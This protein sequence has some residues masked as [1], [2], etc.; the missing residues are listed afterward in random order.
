MAAQFAR[1][2]DLSGPRM[3]LL[4]RRYRDSFP[5][6]EVHPA[7]DPRFEELRPRPPGALTVK[8]EQV[9]TPRVW[10]VGSNEA[11]L[12]QLQ[13]DR[14]V[15]NWRRIGGQDYPRYEHVRAEFLKNFEIFQSFLADEGLGI[16]VLNQWE[17]TYVNH[18]P[19]RSGWNRHGELDSVA[20]VLAGSG[21]GDFL[22]EPEDIALRVRYR[23]PDPE[24]VSRLHVAVN[25]V[26]DQH[27][28][29]AMTL[30]LTARGG[31]GPDGGGSSS[32]E[33]RLNAGREWIVRGF[34]DVTSETMHRLWERK[35]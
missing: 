10:F 32:L 19:A 16:A 11:H 34:A 12:V 14:F 2:K 33:T 4:W 20:P 8:L 9:P 15:F 13:Q 35:R 5:R 18:I 6:L 29:P 1:I 30:T 24:G 22:L 7:L 25:P 27:G 17:L 28:N 21:Q 26:F 31:L 23:M 3:G